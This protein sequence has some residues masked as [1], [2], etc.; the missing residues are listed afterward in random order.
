MKLPKLRFCEILIIIIALILLAY[1]FYD[2]IRKVMTVKEGMKSDEPFYNEVMKEI[3]YKEIDTKEMP[4]GINNMPA[5][6]Q[7]MELMQYCVKGSANSAYSGQYI[8]DEMVKYVLSRGCRFL[9]FEVYYL[10]IGDD[11]DEKD[12]FAPYVGYSSDPSSINSTTKNNYLFRKVLKSTLSNAFTQQS[13]EKYESPNSKDP[14]FIHIRIK[15]DTKNKDKLYDM[16]QSDIQSV[17][18]SGY[19]DYFLVKRKNDVI[20]PTQI[21]GTTSIKRL[22][23]KVVMI[24]DYEPEN[25]IGSFHNMTSDSAQLSR[26]TYDEMN[27]FKYKAMPPK[28]LDSSRTDITK[29][30]MAV[31]DSNRSD[32][33]NPNIHG[34]IKNYGVQFTLIQYYNTDMNLILAE[35]MFQRYSAA[36]LPMSLLLNYIKNSGVSVSHAVSPKLF[37]T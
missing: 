26:M 37:A 24:F 15:T 7:D 35:S 8:S 18:N 10:P 9:D 13:G 21:D 19:N 27:T 12:T 16:I 29:L 14:L 36:I 31:P 32:Q 34:A 25:V 2:Y 33:E 6:S 1:V 11:E 17:F 4:S 28:R 3:G 20:I 5:S 30:K 22:V 23:Q